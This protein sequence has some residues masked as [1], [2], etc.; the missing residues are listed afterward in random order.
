ML[1]SGIKFVCDKSI[2]LVIQKILLAKVFG[3][4][5]VE[6]EN[7]NPGLFSRQIILCCVQ[8]CVH[9]VIVNIFV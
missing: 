9:H 8:V 2:F 4:Q 6:N 5:N 3:R 1:I 7:N